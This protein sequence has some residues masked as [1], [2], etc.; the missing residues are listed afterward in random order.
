MPY[1]NLPKSLWPKMENCVAQVK[2]KGKVDNPYAVCY[3]AVTT[4]KKLGDRKKGKK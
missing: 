1:K 2:A 4:S 3:N